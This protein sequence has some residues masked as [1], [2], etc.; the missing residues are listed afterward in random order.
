MENFAFTS[1]FIPFGNIAVFGLSGALSQ[2]L[3]TKEE[4]FSF[5][6][7]NM[8]GVPTLTSLAFR[9]KNEIVFL[10]ECVLTVNME[11]NIVITPLQGKDG[12]VKEYISDGDYQITVDAAVSSYDTPGYEDRT[13][14]PIE[15]IKELIKLLKVKDGLQIQSDFLTLFGITSV[16]V[17]SYGMVQ[18]THSNRQSFQLQLLSDTPFEIKLLED[19]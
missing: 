1:T 15:Q 3:E 17:K 19:A 18:E 4:D 13:A 6:V 9:Y 7:A 11:K 10:A 5:D 12:T 14:Y 2:P 8:E 16:V